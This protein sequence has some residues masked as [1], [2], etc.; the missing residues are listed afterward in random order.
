MIKYNTFK[1][2]SKVSLYGD[3]DELLNNPQ[4]VYKTNNSPY[5]NC[6]KL[7]FNLNGSLNHLPQLSNNARL[8][9]ESSNIQSDNPQ[10][11]P[12]LW[13]KFDTGSLLTNNGSDNITLINSNNTTFSENYVIGNNAISFNGTNQKLTGTIQNIANNSFSVSVW[14]Y[15]K[16]AAFGTGVVIT[17]G[18]AG[19]SA[20]Q[21][22]LMGFGISNVNRYGFSFWAE[23]SY[24]SSTYLQD[25]NNWVHITWVYNSLTKEKSIY[26]NGVKI[27]VSNSISSSQPIPTNVLTIGALNNNTYYFNGFMDDLRIYTGTA[28]TQNQINDLY[29]KIN[30][31]NVITRLCTSTNDNTTESINF[32]ER[33]PILA[34]SRTNEP[35]YNSMKAYQSLNVPSNF[36]QK[37]YI[38]FEIEYPN[39]SYDITSTEF[40]NSNFSL[41]ITDEDNKQVSDNNIVDFNNLNINVP[42]K[43][44]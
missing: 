17:L 43:Y 18:S 9:L 40:K 5:T 31:Q 26:R 27:T 3:N 6:K 7:R 39:S 8:M 28:L 15:S 37:G 10:L 1:T 32:N 4:S 16:T 44:Y 11:L 38:E 2:V 33:Y 14:L 24:S 30:M 25:I 22:I 29:N 23:D 19:N 41:V 20:Y 21:K 35:F 12:N 34:V 42:I 36:L 13:C